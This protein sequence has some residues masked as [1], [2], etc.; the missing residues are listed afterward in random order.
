MASYW[1]TE[2]DG[3]NDPAITSPVKEMPKP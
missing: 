3:S 2:L 1:P